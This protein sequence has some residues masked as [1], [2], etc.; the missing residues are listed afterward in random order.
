MMIE[1]FAMMRIGSGVVGRPN[2]RIP[3]DRKPVRSLHMRHA[4]KATSVTCVRLAQLPPLLLLIDR[5]EP[6]FQYG[7]YEPFCL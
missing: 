6:P 3:V 2:V 7:G 5:E 4:Q 1:C